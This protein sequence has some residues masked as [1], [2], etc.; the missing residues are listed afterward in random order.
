MNDEASVREHG[1]NGRAVI[2]RRFSLDAMVDG[3]DDLYGRLCAGASLAG[4]RASLSPSRI[5]A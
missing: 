4:T 1:R 3:Y 5:D 2:E